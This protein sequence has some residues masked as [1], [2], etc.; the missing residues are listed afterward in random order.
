M[1]DNL[2]ANKS[3]GT[4]FPSAVDSADEDDDEY[5]EFPDLTKMQ[6]GMSKHEQKKLMIGFMFFDSIQQQQLLLLEDLDL[7]VTT[8]CA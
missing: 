6:N 4:R 2:F 5:K 8:L 1:S 7:L 3:L